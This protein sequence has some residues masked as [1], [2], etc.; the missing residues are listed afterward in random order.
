[1]PSLWNFFRG[2]VI[3]NVQGGFLERFINMCSKLNISLW[4]VKRT[5]DNTF[6]ALLKLPD[7]KK[8]RKV[9]RRTCCKAHFTKR[10]GLPFLIRRLVRHKVFLVGVVFCLLILVSLNMFVWQVNVICDQPF[11]RTKFESVLLESGIKS[12]AL[13]SSLDFEQSKVNIVKECPEISYIYLRRN[14]MIVDVTVALAKKAPK[15]L[16]ENIPCNIVAKRDGVISNIYS[17]IG[18][19]TVR[20]GVL[21][22][23]GQLLISG[24]L[25]SSIETDPLKMVHAVGVVRANTWYEGTKKVVEDQT[26]E[27][28]AIVNAANVL[29]SQL[30]KQVDSLTV[31]KRSELEVFQ[32]EN[33]EKFVKVTLLCEEDIGLTKEI[34]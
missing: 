32:N 33:G 8:I 27:S 10:R 13:I 19:M 2:Y 14:G 28:K 23:K 3:I 18:E 4:K 31:I 15:V 30:E 5:S 25:K 20:A 6:S 17:K 1:M 11:D 22:R 7:V 26:T 24:E 34:G 16:A 9:A 29:K 21:V 12:G